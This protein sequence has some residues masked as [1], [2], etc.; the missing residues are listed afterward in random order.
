[1]ENLSTKIS[2][3]LNH[4]LEWSPCSSLNKKENNKFSRWKI[5]KVKLSK[6]SVKDPS[7]SKTLMAT[8]KIDL[9]N[10]HS[11]ISTIPLILLA[12]ME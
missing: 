4:N 8:G 7:N 9:I 12:F 3:I 10:L 6:V 2:I 5:S 1:M 11:K